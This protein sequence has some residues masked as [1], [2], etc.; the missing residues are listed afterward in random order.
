MFRMKLR[1]RRGMVVG[2]QIVAMGRMRMLGRGFNV[3]A[4]VVFGGFPVVM[5]GL[6]V[7]HCCLLVVVRNLIGMRHRALRTLLLVTD[8]VIRAAYAMRLS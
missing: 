7:M 4:L 6:F 5:G 8:D 3:V 2:M 1:G